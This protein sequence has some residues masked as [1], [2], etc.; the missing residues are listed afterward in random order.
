MNKVKQDS[1]NKT[2]ESSGS[3]RR[4][5]R[6]LSQ[7]IIMLVGIS[8]AMVY[9]FHLIRAQPADEVAHDTA[10][11]R[12]IIDNATRM[13]EEGRQIFRYD[14]FGDEGFWGDTLKLHR[15]IEGVKF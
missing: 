12:Q 9:S 15:A 13:V 6:W 4:R 5:E 1:R 10:A 2:D 14:T 3:S 7:V 8:V 11:D